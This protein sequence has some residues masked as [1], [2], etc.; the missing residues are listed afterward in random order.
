MEYVLVAQDNVREAHLHAVNTYL[1]KPLGH[2]DERIIRK[3][4]WTTWAKYKAD[5]NDEIVVDYATSIAEHGFSGQLEI[6]DFWEVNMK[7]TKH[8][9]FD[10]KITDVL[11]FFSF[12]QRHFWRY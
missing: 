2:P 7:N 8:K 6:D 4:I 1:G 3:P 12:Q 9:G 11:R 5:I 10:N